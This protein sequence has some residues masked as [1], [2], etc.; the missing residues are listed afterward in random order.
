MASIRKEI[1][2]DTQPAAVWAAVKAVGQV[3]THLARGFVTDTTFDGE[4]R[5][6]TFV[7]GLVARER[8]V[9]LDDAGRRLVYASVGGRL[10]H[11]T[12]S[13]QVSEEDDGKTRLVWTTDLLPDEM[14]PAV[15]G[16]MTMGL[17]AIRRTLG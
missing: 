5:V 1:R 10:L 14:A 16:M 4:E 13:F 6:V 7:N 3:H 15:E 12:A 9:T 2:L 17:E 11:H 8:I